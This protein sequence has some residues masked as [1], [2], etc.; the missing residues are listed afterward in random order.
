MFFVDSQAALLTIDKPT[1]N[2]YTVERCIAQLN[3]LGKK[4]SVTLKWVKAHVGHIRNE[5]ADE[6][7]KAG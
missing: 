3:K 6:L 1:V 4:M 7:A 2:S 5:V